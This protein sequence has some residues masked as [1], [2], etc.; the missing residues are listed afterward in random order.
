[1]AYWNIGATDPRRADDAVDGLESPTT[2][3][4]VGLLR[5]GREFMAFDVV[6]NG[7]VHPSTSR[8]G[9]TLRRLNAADKSF[10]HEG[11]RP[12]VTS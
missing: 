11:T 3:L 1:V 12:V 7:R 6:S 4:D 8:W 2:E 5:S 10:R 9:M